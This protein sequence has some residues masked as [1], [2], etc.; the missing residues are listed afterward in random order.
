MVK[1][2]AG[3]LIWMLQLNCRYPIRGHSKDTKIIDCQYLLNLSAH[4]Y[5]LSIQY[6]SFDAGLLNLEEFRHLKS[7]AFQRFLLQ[8]GV[9]RS[10]LVRDS[11]H[12]WLYQGQ[13]AHQVLQDL[14]KRCPPISL[15]AL[16]LFTHQ[17]CWHTA[18]QNPLMCFLHVSPPI[19]SSQ[20]VLIIYLFM[21]FKSHSFNTTTILTGRVKWTTTS[22]ALWA[23]WPLP[24]SSW[25]WAS[26]PWNSL[27]THSPRCQYHLP[28]PD[29][30]Q[31]RQRD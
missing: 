15:F 30:L 10:Q 8:R 29:V 21:S 23:G 17:V 14:R 11:R 9:E 28:I 3:D 7:D 5:V 4:I 31:V 19:H 2:E 20:F 25:Q 1:T 18:F 6:V 26:V 27:H 22:G 12:T 24:C 16:L 13:G